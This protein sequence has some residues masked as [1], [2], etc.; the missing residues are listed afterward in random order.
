MNS[1]NFL[2][3]VFCS[4]KPARGCQDV[5]RNIFMSKFV[6]QKPVDRKD[7]DNNTII[8]KVW[9]LGVS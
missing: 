4:E 5:Y 3:F 9:R 6:Y 2:W 8:L 1:M 7:S